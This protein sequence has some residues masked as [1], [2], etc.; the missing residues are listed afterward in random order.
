MYNYGFRM[1]SGAAT[2][3]LFDPLNDT[4]LVAKRHSNAQ[5]HPGEFSLPGGF[6]EARRDPES[7]DDVK[8]HPGETLAQTAIR[9]VFEETGIVITEDQLHLFGVISDPLLDPRAH[10]INACYWVEV[11][12][13]QI[14]MAFPADDIEAIEWWDISEIVNTEAVK[15][16]AFNH[17]DIAL[18]AINHYDGETSINMILE[19]ILTLE[20]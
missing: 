1:A 20:G 11:T 8:A 17:S 19:S 5:V 14:L 12:N 6:M 4:L 16:T 3:A 9:E 18:D 2:V 10:V 7:D 15:I 13:E